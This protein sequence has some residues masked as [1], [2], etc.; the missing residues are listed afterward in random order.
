MCGRTLLN[1]IAQRSASALTSLW[2]TRSPSHVRSLSQTNLPDPT[3]LLAQGGCRHKSPTTPRS[4]AFRNN[5]TE[6]QAAYSVL[7]ESLMMP[8]EELSV[9]E[10]F[11]T[12]ED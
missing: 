8:H 2:S 4:P 1:D 11:F 9:A 12:D 3:A 7:A 10:N 6:L 5:Q